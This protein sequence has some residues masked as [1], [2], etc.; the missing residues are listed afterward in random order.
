MSRA[1]GTYVA[2][3][4]ANTAKRAYVHFNNDK[5]RETPWSRLT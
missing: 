5:K 1:H 2:S 4:M 3:S